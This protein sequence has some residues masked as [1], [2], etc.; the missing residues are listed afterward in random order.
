MVVLGRQRQDSLCEF[1]ASLVCKASFRTARVA[2]QRNFVSETKKEK[3]ERER[4]RERNAEVVIRKGILKCAP[5][6]WPVT[7]SVGI[8]LIH[9]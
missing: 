2:T 5:S 3:R 8:V 7:M 9:D 6:E 1:K 4:E